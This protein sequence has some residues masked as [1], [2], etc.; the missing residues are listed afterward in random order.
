MKKTAYPRALRINFADNVAVA[1]DNLRRG[2]TIRVA[3]RDGASFELN[4]LD[5]IPFAH[6]IAVQKIKRN[7]RVFKYG[8]T[9]GVATTEISAGEHVHTQNVVSRRAARKR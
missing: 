4:V 7:E 6:K 1:M 8:E 9:I 3:D 2:D 5:P